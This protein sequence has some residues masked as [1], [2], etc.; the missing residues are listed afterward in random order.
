MTT[1]TPLALALS[2]ILA[3]MA[4]H[5]APPEET[6]ASESTGEAGASG[7]VS[8]GAG[9]GPD[10]DAK[11]ENDTKASGDAKDDGPPQYAPE[12]TTA[13]EW[14]KTVERSKPWIKRWLPQ[15]NTVELG[16]FGG[17][18][19]A[20]PAHDFYDPAS[21]PQIPLWSLAPDVGLR[22]AY[23]PLSFLGVE[24]EGGVIP[25]KIR[26]PD[27]TNVLLYHAR[28]H[29]ILRAPWW[30]VAPFLL[31]G[32]GM[33]GVSSDAAAL[34]N[35]IDPV[36]HYGA[37]L[38]IFINH[39][40][41]FRLDGRHLIAAQ[42][43]EQDNRTHHAEVLAGLS[44]TLGRKRPEVPPP[45][46]PEAPSDRDGDTIADF[47]DACPDEPG[48]PDRDGC[49]PPPDTDGDGII[50]END[51]CPEEAGVPEYEGCPIPDTD[52]DGFLDPDDKCISEP[53]TKNG[54]E[55]GDGC[56]DELPPE[57][58]EFSGVIEG[59]LF[60][61]N[62]AKVRKSSAPKLDK[63]IEVLEKF[64]DVRLEVVGHT[65]DKGSREYNLDLSKRRAQSVVDYLVE[66][67]IDRSR[68]RSRGAGPDEPMV[69]NDSNANRAK[70]RRTEFRVLTDEDLAKID[71]GMAATPVPVEDAP[72]EEPP[73]DAP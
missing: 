33:M 34:G 64:P 48:V 45:P 61:Y 27:N 22:V 14:E 28:G 60:E 55:D 5:A 31:G 51:R 40:L 41:A 29:A 19:I 58:E 44:L 73:T 65:D 32:F 18:F 39:Y 2:L 37:G 68:L 23:F 57:M 66:G 30:R 63:A 11:A 38:E 42:E 12:G 47:D 72:D 10:G 4:A 3:P 52:G 62:S 71:G 8:L 1:R 7:S 53:E 6:G 20:N 17:I 56:P 59:I 69:P 67:G 43:R 21:A 26:D 25:N 16:V 50:D 36:A 54:F 24:V 13:K 9:A 49:P 15:R 46:P 70:N 35:D